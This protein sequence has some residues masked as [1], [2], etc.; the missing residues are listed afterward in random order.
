VVGIHQAGRTGRR[1]GRAAGEDNHLVV[2]SSP[3]WRLE[4]SLAEEAAGLAI[5]AEGLGG[6]RMREVDRAWLPL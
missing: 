6:H 1:I 3:Y 5:L 2:H 4:R